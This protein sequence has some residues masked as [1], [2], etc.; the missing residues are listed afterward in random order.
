MAELATLT[1]ALSHHVQDVLDCGGMT[2]CVGRPCL[3]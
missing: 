3:L 1:R 2:N